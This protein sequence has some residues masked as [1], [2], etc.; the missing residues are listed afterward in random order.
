MCLSRLFR[1]KERVVSDAKSV[2][3]TEVKRISTTLSTAS[4]AIQIVLDID[5][6]LAVAY[7]D[8]DIA[9]CP[10]LTA[11]ARNNQ[12]IAVRDHMLVPA[13]REFIQYLFQIPDC[14]ISFF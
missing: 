4:T 3:P 9:W 2:I 8:E 1:K 14:K 7:K 12:I 13:A 5:E 6:M 11:W 10:Q